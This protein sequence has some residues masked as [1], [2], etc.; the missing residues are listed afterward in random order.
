MNAY[1]CRYCRQPSDPAQPT[2]PLCGAPVDVRDH[3]SE[4]GW[5]A[6]PP[7][8]DMARLQFGQ[9]HL[10][11]AGTTVPV[12]EFNLAQQDWIYFSHHTLLWTDTQAR[13]GNMPMRG[14]WKRVMAGLPLIMMEARGP[15]HVALSDNH[16]GEVVA[17]PLQHGQQMWVREHRFLC[18]TGT[19]AYDWTSND[20]WYTTGQD[21]NDQ[22]THYPMGQFGDIFTARTGPDANTGPGLLLLHARG[23]TFIRDLQPGQSLLVQPSSL[24]Y[25]DMSVRLNLHLEYPRNTGISFW[26]NR[27]SYRNVWIRLHGPGRIAVQSVYEPPENTEIIQRSSYATTHRW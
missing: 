20:V 2:C 22:E 18:A 7:I 13:L 27:L 21:R 17:L 1:I 23:N 26:N 5:T 12:A 4:T 6:Q 9:S 10:Q 8:R 14:G 11:I 3:V 19:I 15:G 16:A 24:L 25:R